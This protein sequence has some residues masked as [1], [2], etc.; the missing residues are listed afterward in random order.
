MGSENHVKASG[1]LES[2]SQ[3]AS[4]ALKVSWVPSQGVLAANLCVSGVGSRTQCAFRE[5]VDKRVLSGRRPVFA[6][7]S[8]G[9]GMWHEDSVEAVLLLRSDDKAGRWKNLEK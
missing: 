1:L 8:S 2:L 9:P 4:P 3:S 6:G 7:D 5:E